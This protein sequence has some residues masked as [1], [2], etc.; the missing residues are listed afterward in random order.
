MVA[1]PSAADVCPK[2]DRKMLRLKTVSENHR[3]LQPYAG[4]ADLSHSAKQTGRAKIWL[5]YSYRSNTLP[6]LPAW[7]VTATWLFQSTSIKLVDSHIS[8]F[9]T[10]FATGTLGAIVQVG[11]SGGLAV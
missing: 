11:R 6:A 8:Y 5:N 4:N 3:F 7:L 10:I 9:S 2:K 1:E